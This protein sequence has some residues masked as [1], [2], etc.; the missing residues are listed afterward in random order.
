MTK[1]KKIAMLLSVAVLVVSCANEDEEMDVE[2]YEVAE[3]TRPEVQREVVSVGDRVYF[4]LNQYS[5]NV[6]AK[7]VLRLQAESLRNQP[8]TRIII[9]GHCDERGTRDYNIALGAR[10]ASEV[11]NFLIRSGVDGRR[12]KTISYGKERPVM[13]G[14]GEAVWAKNRV[15]ITVLSN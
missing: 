14:H 15:A 11:K 6:E 9:E 10:R 7:D 13:E 5:L 12:I 1:L 2:A 3:S 4:D 8:T